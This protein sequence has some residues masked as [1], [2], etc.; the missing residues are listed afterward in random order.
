[1][2]G[3]VEHTERPD[4]VSSAASPS[5]GLRNYWAL[6]ERKGFSVAGAWM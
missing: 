4:V 6:T 2:M 1:M 5:P 3:S